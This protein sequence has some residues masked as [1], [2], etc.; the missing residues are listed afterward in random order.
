MR[1]VSLYH[2][3]RFPAEIISHCVWLYFRFA[4]N[5]RDVEELMSTR[6]V[7]LSYETVREWC[8]KFG[9]TYANGLRRRSLRPGDQWHLDEV[10]LKIN[11]RLHYLWRA[12]DQD[13]GVLDILVQTSRDKK[14]AKKF[15]RKL[16]KGLRYV[17]RV[18]VTDK[19][20][21]YSAA[22][23]EVMPSV[24]HLQQKYQ[25]NRAENSHQPTRLR[26]RLMRGFKSTGHAQRFLSVFGIIS[27]HFRVGRHLHGAGAYRALMK[28]R[29]AD[30]KEAICSR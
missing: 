12:V 14:A 23:A 11:G 3:H 24:E 15:F 4:L 26:E 8:F 9:Q 13:G 19:L 1:T 10:F 30:W 20:R 18:I 22:K 6:G 27:S 28:S 21:S 25:N 17:P 29:F 16:L 5:F 7:S 2:R